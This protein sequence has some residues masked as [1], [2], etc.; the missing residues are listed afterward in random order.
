MFFSLETKYVKEC[1]DNQDSNTLN[2]FVRAVNVDENGKLLKGPW[3]PELHLLCNPSPKYVI[4]LSILISTVVFIL[5][6]FV[7]RK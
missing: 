7:F 2:A 3:S 4:Y 5:L 1:T 6:F